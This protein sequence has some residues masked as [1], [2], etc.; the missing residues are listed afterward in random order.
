MMIYL[1]AN[2]SSQ[3]R[4]QVVQA[5]ETHLAQNKLYGN[6][7]SV[8]ATGRKSKTLIVSA[9]KAILDLFF[10]GEKT[11]AQL[12]FTSGGSEGCNSLI[13]GFI[14]PEVTGHLLSSAIEHP[15]I[16]EPLKKLERCGFELELVSPSKDGFISVE[17]FVSKVKLSTALVTVMLANNETGAI[18]P[19]IQ[20]AKALREK[21]Y[22]GPIVSD[23]TQ[24]VA[25]SE[26]N[27]K[28]L[29]AAGVT[30][31]SISGHKLG[32]LTGVG[33][34]V[35]S[36]ASSGNCFQ[37]Q[38]TILG[39]G[40][41]HGFRSGTENLLGILSLME[42]C[43]EIKSQGRSE[44]ES[45]SQ[46]RERLWDNLNLEISGLRRLSSST[47]VLSNT[48]LLQIEGCRS[49]DL[50]VAL[51]LMDVCAS[52]GSACNSGKQNASYVPISMGLSQKESIE[53]IRFSLDWD[54]TSESIDE[55]S[56][57][58]IQAVKQMRELSMVE[59]PVDIHFNEIG[60]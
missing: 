54:A 44:R 52:R 35:V 15:A 46:L 24:A 5:L 41:Q 36:G 16:S 55:A 19:V 28:E 48:L 22:S 13:N 21:K 20:I 3:L 11:D 40:Q 56:K 17:E 39:G 42:A 12:F 29:F 26:V 34:I 57:R 23:I 53:V 33:A 18:Q 43:K 8:Y 7:S 38:P 4:P 30:A 60:A 1:D 27:L 31:V 51:D 59:Q 2:A 45:I 50:V 58:I 32:A 6:A 9:K 10:P 37:F 25:K 47:N 14:D 49:D